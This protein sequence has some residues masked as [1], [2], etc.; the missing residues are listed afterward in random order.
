MF[1]YV[2][3]YFW[4]LLP[5][6]FFFLWLYALVKR[7][8]NARGRE[9]PREYLREFL[10][11]FL[12]LLLALWLDSQVIEAVKETVEVYWE[13]AH[14]LRWLVYPAL[15]LAGAYADQ[16]FRKKP[17]QARSDRTSY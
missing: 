6:A 11:C 9:Y 16:L 10:F 2:Y 8:T 15:L 12:A 7:A 4:A 13:D 3:H 1:T 14:Y 5:L 17:P